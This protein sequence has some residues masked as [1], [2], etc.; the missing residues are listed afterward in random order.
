MPLSESGYTE[1]GGGQP[2]GK[3]A[4]KCGS[5]FYNGSLNDIRCDI[6]LFFICEHE[7]DL[8]RNDQDLRFG[9]VFT[10]AKPHAGM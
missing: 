1:W 4:E 6:N 8:L 3:G 9:E 5:M 7:I 10:T 2:D